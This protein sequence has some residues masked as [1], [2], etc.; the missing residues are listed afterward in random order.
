MPLGNHFPPEQRK[1][2]IYQNLLPGRVIFL[3]CDFAN[4]DKYLLLACVNPEL[5]FFVIN[6]RVNQFVAKHDYL[7]KCQVA[8]GPIHHDFLQHDS[9]INCTEAKSL[10]FQDIYKQLDKDM[11][12]IKGEIST[13]V[14][15]QVISAV[16]FARTLSPRDKNA[17]IVALER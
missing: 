2:V 5:L 9:Y 3:Y 12:R 13:E 6:S 1:R 7:L 10:S 16:K 14:R 17:I 11:S 4:K 8:V 15:D